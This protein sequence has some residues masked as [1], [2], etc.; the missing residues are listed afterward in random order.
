MDW[1]IIR[2]Y[3]LGEIDALEDLMH[4][5]CSRLMGYIRIWIRV[6]DDVED[7]FQEVY[8]RVWQNR[9]LLNSP[10]EFRPWMYGITR[11][12]VFDFLRGKKWEKVTCFFNSEDDLIEVHDNSRSALQIAQINEY[13]VILSDA[14]GDLESKLQEVVALRFVSDLTFQEIAL[15]L[16]V[17]YGTVCSRMS[18]AL[19]ELRRRLG[20]VDSHE[21]SLDLS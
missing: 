7:I 2:R 1:E 5:E 4:C 19:K 10:Q 21:H 17:P 12:V 13:R 11:H 20:G 3:Q 14:I 9:T 15:T 8:C 18:R 16:N 6:E